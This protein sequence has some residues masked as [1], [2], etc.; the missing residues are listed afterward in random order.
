MVSQRAASP[1]TS[2]PACPAISA[3][4]I[5]LATL[6]TGCTPAAAPATTTPTV[7]LNERADP[8]LGPFSVHLLASKTEMEM[9]GD[10]NIGVTTA[11]RKLLDANPGI[12][13]IHLNSPGGETHEGYLLGLLIKERHLTTYTST[14]CASAC[15]EAFLSGS[16]RYLA[17][18]AKLGFH[19]PSL[20]GAATD[21][22]N[23]AMRTFY[24]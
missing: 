23:D 15:T 19:S 3:L 4:V 7:A 16:P 10:M 17:K 13:I 12:Q 20:G 5:T 9:T 18:G 22:G 24:Q 11:V 6:L 2:L 14:I 1:T 21:I 8:G